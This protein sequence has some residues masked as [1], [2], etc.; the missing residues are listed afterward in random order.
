MN[1][2]IGIIALAIVLEASLHVLIGS[3]GAGYLSSAWRGWLMLISW[4]A[5]YVATLI[6]AKKAAIFQ[7]N[8]F[9][10]RLGK[11]ILI[12]TPVILYGS[13]LA[14]LLLILIEMP[15]I[16]NV[17]WK[18][19]FQNMGMAQLTQLSSAI[20]ALYA[21]KFS[22][23]LFIGLLFSI[24]RKSVYISSDEKELQAYGHTTK[25]VICRKWVYRHLCF[26]RAEY[27]VK[28]KRYETDSIPVP[29]ELLSENDSVTILYSTRYP[30][31]SIIEETAH[32]RHFPY[33]EKFSLP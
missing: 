28:G 8:T 33:K 27:Y 9:I 13:M 5:T 21:I 7:D 17:D 23:A 26:V 3:L 6:F 14:A 20:S 22:L 12:C 2:L 25:G 19:I 11:A 15:S 24:R 18:L 1:K 32:L 4:A 29:T 31:I 16:K 30:L 10:V